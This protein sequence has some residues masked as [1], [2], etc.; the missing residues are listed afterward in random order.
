MS[1]SPRHDQ[2]VRSFIKLLLETGW[3]D[4][5][6]DLPEYTC[7]DKI[8]WKDKGTGHIPDVSAYHKGAFGIFEVE[9]EQSIALQ[10]T[11]DQFT[12]FGA[13]AVQHH[14]VF[15]AAVPKSIQGTATQVLKSVGVNAVVVPL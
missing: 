8:I 15:A 2:L 14:A 1:S 12:L 4:I 6:A 3:T 11:A 10:H 7:P 5:K 13:F 9:D